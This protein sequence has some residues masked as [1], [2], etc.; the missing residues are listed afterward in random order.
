MGT[1]GGKQSM[2]VRYFN[3][4]L[5]R[6]PDTH[7][8][9]LHLTPGYVLEPVRW[10]FGGRIGLD[11]CTTSDNPVAADQFITPPADGAA[12]PWVA[13]TIWC[14]PP[15]GQARNRWVGRCI[16]AG[17]AG[18]RVVLL[19]P[20][21]TDTQVFQRALGSATTVLFV[22]GRIKFGTP[23]PDGSGRQMAASHPSALLGWNVDLR[24]I[25]HLGFAA[26]AGGFPGVSAHHQEQRSA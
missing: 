13:D 16:E 15:Y 12:A 22:Q 5:R 21:H 19:I 9:Q 24:R 11:P 1:A 26:P 18:A 17:T 23:R 2:A 10:L 25:D 6:R 8:G 4:D 7:D 14:N 20:A 3:N